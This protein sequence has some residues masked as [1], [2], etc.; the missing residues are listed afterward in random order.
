MLFFAGV[1]LLILDPHAIKIKPMNHDIVGDAIVFAG[2]GFGAMNAYINQN[3]TIKYHPLLLMVHTF[4]FSTI[5][6]FIFLLMFGGPSIVSMECKV[7]VFGWFCHL[8]DFLVV[9]FG[10][11]P[12]TGVLGNLCFIM[13]LKYFPHEVVT[14][15]ILFEPFLA[16]LVG[17]HMK[18]DQVPGILTLIGLLVIIS[19]SILAFV[20]TKLRIT[21]QIKL[22]E[23]ESKLQL[24]MMSPMNRIPSQSGK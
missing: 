14:I 13:A 21:E 6:Q 22:I 2:A 3:S 24:S 17:L 16:H 15:A 5:Y 10:L 9:I 19:G 18:I 23:N 1:V 11:V 8:K 12:F 20:G 7:G 4:T